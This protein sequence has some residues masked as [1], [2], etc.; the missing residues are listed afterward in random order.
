MKGGVFIIARDV[1]PGNSHGVP[2]RLTP[3][4]IPCKSSGCLAAIEIDGA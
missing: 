1:P 4:T 3:A 2:A